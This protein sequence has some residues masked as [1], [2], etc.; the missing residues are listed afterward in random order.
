VRAPL[1]A[2]LCDLGPFEKNVFELP[3]DVVESVNEHWGFAFDAFG[4][5]RLHPGRAVA[6]SPS[7]EGSAR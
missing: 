7:Q 4:Y 6:P 3:G 1:S 2:Y 5:E